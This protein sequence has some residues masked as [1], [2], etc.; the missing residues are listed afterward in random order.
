M[1]FSIVVG[2]GSFQGD[3]QAGWLAIERLALL[4]YPR[5]LL[6]RA[7]S[8][9]EILDVASLESGLIICDACQIVNG[10]SEFHENSIHEGEAAILRL[11]WPTDALVNSHG[12]GSHRQNLSEVLHLGRIL[13]SIPPTA[14][15][16]TICGCQW[17]AG[18]EPSIDVR[19]ASQRVA[20]QI[21][22]E[23]HHA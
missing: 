13:N 7:R 11:S 1:S 18:C 17:G 23:S 14:E 16:W 19:H 3:D 15:L 8:P 10:S 4:G 22:S 9:V 20:Q 21:W 12:G 6:H 5:W 2:L